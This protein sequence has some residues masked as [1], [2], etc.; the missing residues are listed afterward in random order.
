M[1]DGGVTERNP[2]KSAT[3]ELPLSKHLLMAFA[4]PVVCYPWP[5]SEPLNR[6]LADLILNAERKDDGITRSNVGGWHSAADFFDWQAPAIKVLR[7]RVIE[8]TMAITRAIAVV[9]EGPRTFN[10]RIDG[11]AN[12]SR[13]GHYNA[14][15][16][17]PNCLWS[18]TYY[19]CA[20]KPD[21]DTPVNGRLELLDP[22]AGANMV[23]AA[24][25]LLQSRYLI[26]PTPGLMVLFPSWLNHLVHPFFGSGERISIAFNILTAAAKDTTEGR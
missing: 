17:H 19:V 1:S 18:G 9:K 7:E 13:N 6:G 20:G 24:N 26:T 25:T 15:H 22:R 8:M 14:V 12:V 23:H 11:W 21:P 10:Y 16:N 4:T 3:G 5:E 2:T